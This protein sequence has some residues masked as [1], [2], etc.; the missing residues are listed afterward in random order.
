MDNTVSVV[1]CGDGE[2]NIFI[3]EFIKEA[4]NMGYNMDVY[5]DPTIP[6]ISILIENTIYLYYLTFAAGRK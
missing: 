2:K 3:N 6:A 5:K 1:Y 4:G